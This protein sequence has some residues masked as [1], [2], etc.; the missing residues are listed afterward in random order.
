MNIDA[1]GPGDVC[2]LPA[3]A[4]RGLAG[5]GHAMGAVSCSAV[6]RGGAG[7]QVK[8]Y[9][10]FFSFFVFCVFYTLNS[11]FPNLKSRLCGL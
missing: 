9:E 1:D 10:S 8:P 5:A 11:D 2:S 6:A 3:V 4:G 7:K